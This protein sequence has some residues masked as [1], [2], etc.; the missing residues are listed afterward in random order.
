[1]ATIARPSRFLP[2]ASPAHHAHRL[3]SSHTHFATRYPPF[4]PPT[5][6]LTHFPPPKT[7]S[8]LHSTF[9]TPVT[10]SGKTAHYTAPVA[11]RGSIDA[12]RIRSA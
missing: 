9:A 3:A 2:L 4:A 11:S 5:P 1:M 6:P 8:I 12:T 7:P 10:N